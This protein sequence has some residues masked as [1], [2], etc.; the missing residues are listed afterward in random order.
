M[1]YRITLLCNAEEYHREEKIATLKTV[2]Y[3]KVINLGAFTEGEWVRA[4]ARKTVAVDGKCGADSHALCLLL[5]ERGII[6][7]RVR[8][9]LW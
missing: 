8:C 1:P 6:S 2:S 9:N 4:V 7:S 5:S 3:Q